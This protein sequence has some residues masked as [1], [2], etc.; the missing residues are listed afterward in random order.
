MAVSGGQDSMAL[1]GLL[2]DLRRLHGWE[3]W[4]WHGDHGWRAESA[5]QA[6][7]LAAW[8]KGEGLPLVQ[9]R[10]E[11]GVGSEAAARSWRYDRLAQQA[12]ALGCTRVLTGHTADDRAES[13]LLHLARG[14][15]LKGLASPRRSRP[16]QDSTLLVRPLLGMCRRETGE[17]CQREALPV[18]EDPS[19]GSLAHARNRI[20][21]QVLPVLEELHPGAGQRLAAL[22]EQL[23]KEGN[24]LEEMLPLALASLTRGTEGQALDRRRLMALSTSI[25]G[26]LL[27]HWLG[28]GAGLALG[29]RPLADLLRRLHPGQGPG[30]LDLPR[31]WRLC[32]ERVEIRLLPPPPAGGP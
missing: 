22:S 4:I 17:F 25:Q 20:R 15:H 3:L 29:S 23:E 27:L 7:A 9:D 8:A 24:P 10:S 21:H 31:G 32:W 28:Q 18:W 6:L 1:V 14:A 16:L 2:R 26:H 12:S 30:S 11:T 19:N 5:D 13:L